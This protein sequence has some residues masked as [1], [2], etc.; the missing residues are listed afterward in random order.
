MS[1]QLSYA[2][3]PGTSNHHSQQSPINKNQHLQP[4]SARDNNNENNN[5]KK[6]NIYLTNIFVL[7]ICVLNCAM[8]LN[9]IR[10]VCL[11]GAG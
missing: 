4:I 1:L 8:Y 6:K 11:C 2:S 7:K 3:W 9:I 5:K 10:F